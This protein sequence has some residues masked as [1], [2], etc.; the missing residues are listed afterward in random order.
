M[1]A[2][3]KASSATASA[4]PL[5]AMLEE[6]ERMSTRV[7]HGSKLA[8]CAANG[9]GCAEEELL[10]PDSDLDSDSDSDPCPVSSTAEF[11]EETFVGSEDG[12]GEGERG[13]RDIAFVEGS[14]CAFALATPTA[15]PPSSSL[16]SAASIG[17]V[18]SFAMA[19][20]ISSRLRWAAEAC[21]DEVEDEDPTP[22]PQFVL[23]DSLR[24]ARAMLERRRAEQL[25]RVRA[26][27]SQLVRERKAAVQAQ[28]QAQAQKLGSGRAA[29]EGAKK[30]AA[31]R[32]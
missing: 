12:E 14:V 17:V 28:A 22:N 6:L 24:Q 26:Y 2:S 25:A 11:E 19:P 18:G 10:N 23:E 29:K 9:L 27:Q 8:S 1:S 7:L 20:S 30:A 31:R 15:A 16:T 3:S 13:V 32:V 5:D 21:E 4:S